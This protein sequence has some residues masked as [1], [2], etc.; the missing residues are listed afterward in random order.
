M[1]ISWALTALS[2]LLASLVLYSIPRLLF[3]LVAQKQ[4]LILFSSTALLLFI[5]LLNYWGL[6]AAPT[7]FFFALALAFGF[8]D[9]VF[10]FSLYLN[11]LIF[12]PWE[13][14]PSDSVFSLIPR[15]GGIFILSLTI[16]DF[17]LNPRRTHFKASRIIILFFIWCLLS[18]LVSPTSLDSAIEAMTTFLPSI[19]LF[20]L[21]QFWM[22]TQEDYDLLVESIAISLVG[23][24][25]LSIFLFLQNQDQARIESVGIFANSNDIAAL[26]VL[27]IPLALR[28]YF[29]QINQQRILSKLIALMSLGPFLIVVYLAKSR[30]AWLG[31]FS[32]F[33][34]LISIKSKKISY[35]KLGAMAVLAIAPSLK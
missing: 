28:P 29:S 21:I 31:L 6:T 3:R 18:A 1:T 24:S 26:C 25:L 33:A 9:H 17:W 5:L 8:V 27:A 16:L 10:G 35:F 15:W 32:F 19:I 22:K 4:N 12:R 7:A 2:I 20:F 14:W 30:G 23:V 13:L 34:V 11:L